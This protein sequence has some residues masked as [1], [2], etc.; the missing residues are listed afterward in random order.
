MKLYLSS[1]GVPDT[2][3][4]VSLFNKHQA[5]QVAL[6]T[7]AW[8]VAPQT[9]SAPFIAATTKMITNLGFT[10]VS[11]DLARLK[12]DQLEAQLK[13]ASGIWVTGGNT[14]YLNYWMRESGFD[15]LLPELLRQGVVYGG[16]S[17]GAVV[18]GKTLHGIELLDNPAEA[19]DVL[20]P[21]LSLVDYSIIPHWGE[22]KYADRIEQAYEEMRLFS[23]VKRLDNQSIIIAR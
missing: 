4:Y 12:S 3:A 5:R 21:G 7:T 8:N 16:E 15:K 23:P 9:K 10:T 17:A 2:K 19:P 1:L 6:I 18:A 20:W 14:F 13:G 22:Q 11:L